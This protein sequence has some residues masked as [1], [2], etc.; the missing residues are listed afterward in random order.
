MRIGVDLGGTKIKGFALGGGPSTIQPL[1]TG[2]P[3]RWAAYFR[4]ESVATRLAAP[5]PGDANGVRGA[6]RRWPA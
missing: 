4:C 3:A 5:R 2:V 6:A 1:H